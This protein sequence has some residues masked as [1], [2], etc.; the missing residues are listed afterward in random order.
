MQDRLNS[1][2]RKVQDVI[3]SLGFSFEVLELP[4]ST[5]SAREAAEAIGCRV[6]Q[7]AKSI[8][9]KAAKS[10]RPVLVITSGTNRVSEQRISE[11]IGEAVEK[12]SAEFVRASTGFSIGGVPPVGHLKEPLAFI[13]TDLFQHGEIWAAAGT[14][15]AVFRLTPD[16]LVKITRAEVVRVT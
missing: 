4:E 7:I 16:S 5:R 14:P 10:E 8:I 15:H 11:Y 9:F 3:R 2:A 12:A 1:S 13:D 6:E